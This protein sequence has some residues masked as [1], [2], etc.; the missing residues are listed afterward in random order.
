[1]TIKTT[2]LLLYN[3]LSSTLWL[4]IFLNVIAA[5]LSPAPPSTDT[6]DAPLRSAIN[7]YPHLEPMTRWTQTL[8]IAEILHAAIGLAF[9]PFPATQ[10][11]VPKLTENRTHPRPRHHDL[12]SGLHALRPSLGR[13]L[14]VSR[15]DGVVARLPGSPAGLVRG[16]CGAVCVFR[17]S[18]GGVPG[19][20]CCCCC[21]CIN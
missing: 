16:G 1:M 18:V 15:A 3:T 5:L 7:V 8:A 20:C 11:Q 10:M 14:P 21:Y 17:V 9:P 2:Y 12:H 13:E 4:C 6:S 19:G